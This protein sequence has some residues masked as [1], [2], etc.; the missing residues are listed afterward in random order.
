VNPPSV[1]TYWSAKRSEV[2]HKIKKAG[3]SA[4]L[5]FNEAELQMLRDQ[6]D[7]ALRGNDARLRT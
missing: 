2:N 1:V 7:A 6:I 5:V 4:F 3:T